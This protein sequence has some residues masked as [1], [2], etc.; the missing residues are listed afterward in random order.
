VYEKKSEKF[1]FKTHDRSNPEKFPK[2]VLGGL[3]ELH[4][5]DVGKIPEEEDQRLPP[6]NDVVI[7]E[8]NKN[9]QGYRVEK[10][11]PDQG[12][13][14]EAESKNSTLKRLSKFS[15]APKNLSSPSSSSSLT[16]SDFAWPFEQQQHDGSS[17]APIVPRLSQSE[18]VLLSQ[19][20]FFG[21]GGARV[22]PVP[23]F[24][25]KVQVAS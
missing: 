8:D 24:Y 18:K 11:V 23:K 17:L 12:P 4:E 6:V 2:A 19:Y 10:D 5:A 16:K 14:C 22:Q 13:G 3:V 7:K 25:S 9:N 20:F 1:L 15:A 21:G